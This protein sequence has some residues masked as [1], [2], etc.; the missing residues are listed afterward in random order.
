MARPR[1]V[2][3]SFGAEVGTGLK[4]LESRSG[5]IPQPWSVTVRATNGGVLWK[6]EVLKN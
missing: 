6:P 2:A 1:P 5:G 4:I 3:L